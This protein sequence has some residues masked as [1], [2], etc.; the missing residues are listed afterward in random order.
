MALDGLQNRLWMLVFVNGAWFR[1]PF[2]HG[3]S[4]D[5]QAI[6]NKIASFSFSIIFFIE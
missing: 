3:S 1:L 6:P 5:D 4:L 2:I